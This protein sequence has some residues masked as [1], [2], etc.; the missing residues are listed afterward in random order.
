MSWAW[1]Q[2][3]K[4]GQAKTGPAGPL[5]TALIVVELTEQYL[6]VMHC[7]YCQH[8]GRMSQKSEAIARILVFSIPEAT[9]KPCGPDPLPAER[10]GKGSGP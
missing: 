8:S 3:Q 6:L 1:S 2:L 7:G 10:F 5:A 9:K 4:S